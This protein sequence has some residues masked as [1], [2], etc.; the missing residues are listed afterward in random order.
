VHVAWSWPAHERPG[1]RVRLA[2]QPDVLR[3][4]TERLGHEHDLRMVYAALRAAEEI[5]RS[6]RSAARRVV[7]RAI[8]A[9]SGPLDA[10]KPVP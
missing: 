8:A 1:R 3:D 2:V 5:D 9:V 7:R 10:A 4:L 6:D